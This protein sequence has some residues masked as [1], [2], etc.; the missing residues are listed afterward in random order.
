MIAVENRI[1]RLVEVRFTA[2][3]TDDDIDGFGAQRG[4]ALEKATE[5]VVCLDVTRMN[6]LPPEQSD[7]LLEAL[8]GPSPGRLRS[9][10]LLP[11]GR[12]VVT[13]QFER[14]IR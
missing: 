6:V 1:G 5:R 7:R 4:R 10:F 13:L 14:L 8:R 3:V 9:A 2:P 11:I 12:A